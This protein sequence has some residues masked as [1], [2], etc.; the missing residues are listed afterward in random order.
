MDYEEVKE[1][2]ARLSEKQ[3]KLRTNLDRIKEIEK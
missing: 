2:H 1:K 3:Q